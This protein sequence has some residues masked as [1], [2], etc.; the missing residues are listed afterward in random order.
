MLH[1]IPDVKSLKI[2]EGF[3]EIKEICYKHIVCDQRVLTALQTLPYSENGAEL[4]LVIASEA[5]EGYT[6]SVQARKIS[7]AAK[8]PAGAF[9]AVQTLRQLFTHK[10]A[11]GLTIGG[12]F[13][14]RSRA[15][16][17]EFPADVGKMDGQG[18]I[19]CSRR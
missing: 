11:A 6:I 2:H 14:G 10:K 9:Y 7:I 17:A 13:I 19:E 8:G 15:R 4:E 1:L 3:L 16:P 12:F 18:G 5:G